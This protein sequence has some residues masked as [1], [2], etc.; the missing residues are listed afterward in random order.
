MK[1]R[2]PDDVIE[3]AKK[4]KVKLAWISEKKWDKKQA[5]G[6]KKNPGAVAPGMV[7][8]EKGREA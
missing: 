3:D 5:D 7:F 4:R 2:I 1:L 8:A 6:W